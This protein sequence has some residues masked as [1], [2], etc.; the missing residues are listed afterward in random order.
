VFIKMGEQSLMFSRFSKFLIIVLV[1][2]GLKAGTQMGKA[3][4]IAIVTPPEVISASIPSSLT[5]VLKLSTGPYNLFSGDPGDFTVSGAINNPLIVGVNIVGQY[6]T[7][8]LSKPIVSSDSPFLTYA[9]TTSV[10]SNTASQVLPSFGAMGVAL[11]PTPTVIDV[12]TE[13]TDKIVLYMSA[14]MLDYSFPVAGDP[15]V[16]T[17][18]GNFHNNGISVVGVSITGYYVTLQLNGYISYGDKFV[19]NYAPTLTSKITNGIYDLPAISPGKVVKNLVQYEAP[20]PQISAVIALDSDNSAALNPG[21]HIRIYFNTGLSA[22]S[23]ILLTE[24]FNSA[25]YD[26]LGTTSKAITWRDSNA[27][28]D[29]NL[30]DSSG[31]LPFIQLGESITFDQELIVNSTGQSPVSNLVAFVPNE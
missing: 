21:D 11:V 23:A 8:T 24:L 6:V 13:Y 25:A 20:A 2:A 28:V 5:I 1:V 17:L 15:D 29:I 3:N 10:I 22:D 14:S 18:N 9:R 30:G 31:T 12:T 27:A 26:F 16:F 4:A 19:V 7:L